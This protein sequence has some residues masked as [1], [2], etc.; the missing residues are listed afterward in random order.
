MNLD[1]IRKVIKEELKAHINDEMRD[2]IRAEMKAVIRDEVGIRLDALD[3]EINV[4]SD[5]SRTLE[6]VDKSLDFTSR[7][8]DDLYSTALPA[9]TSHIETIATGLAMQTLDLD[10]H[11]RK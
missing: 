6:G 2:L 3:R 7:R 5:L 9:I 8:I 11:R 1:D 4:I 10:M